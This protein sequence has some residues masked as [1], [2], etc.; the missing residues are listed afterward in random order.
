MSQ[1]SLPIQGPSK[2]GDVSRQGAGDASADGVLAAFGDILAGLAGKG[3]GEGEGAGE[4][5]SLLALGLTPEADS[6][7]AAADGAVA[8]DA[9]LVPAPEQSSRTPGSEA[10]GDDQEMPPP[11]SDSDE[12]TGAGAQVLT[13]PAALG[14]QADG[15]TDAQAMRPGAEARAESRPERPAEPGTSPQ[16]SLTEEAERLLRANVRG[17]RPGEPGS[18]PQSP[19]SEDAERLLRANARGER[20]VEPVEPRPAPADRAAAAE[21]AGRRPGSDLMQMLLSGE[22]ARG[23]PPPSAQPELVASQFHQLQEM[24]AESDGRSRLAMPAAP[25]QADLAQSSP[26]APAVRAAVPAVAVEIAAQA[27]DGNRQFTIQLDPPELG[28]VD[29]R[30]DI[31]RDGAMTAKL[32]VDRPET[33]DLLVRDARALERTLQENGFRLDEDGVQ[34]QLRDQPGFA[35]NGREGAGDGAAGAGGEAGSDADGDGAAGDDNGGPRR[36]TL[37]GIDMR[38]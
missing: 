1:I 23:Q 37:G 8:R 25:P 3:E 14:A 22:R 38:V 32:V 28:R 33:L 19:Q 7:P 18:P 17:E 11:D 12:A 24:G 13:I 4:G 15:E 10:Q 35:G 31:A 27:R 26:N 29:V 9:G 20:P 30:L 34:Y 16:R 36:V 6:A 2:G 5:A 21:E